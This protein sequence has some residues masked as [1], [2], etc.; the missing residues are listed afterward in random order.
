MFLHI[1]LKVLI[2]S[3]WKQFETDGT[4]ASFRQRI[5]PVVCVLV[6]SEYVWSLQE[7]KSKMWICIAQNSK[8]QI[9]CNKGVHWCFVNKKNKSVLRVCWK[10]YNVTSWCFT[11]VSGTLSYINSSVFPFT[12]SSALQ[13]CCV[14]TI[15]NYSYIPSTTV[16]S[17]RRNDTRGTRVLCL[18]ILTIQR[19]LDTVLRFSGGF[20]KYKVIIVCMLFNC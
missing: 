5:R 15:V 2:S 8:P 12:W 1:V 6:L 3:A 9:F 16:G 4:P 18:Q 11:A 10:P 17:S 7:G 14:V 13:C 19:R 20:N